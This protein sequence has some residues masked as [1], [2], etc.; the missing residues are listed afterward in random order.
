[1]NWPMI[2]WD[3]WLDAVWIRVSHD[4]HMIMYSPYHH[5]MPVVMTTLHVVV[6]MIVVMS[7]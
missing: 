2:V 6:V 7:Y 1:M 3:E 4:S 5:G